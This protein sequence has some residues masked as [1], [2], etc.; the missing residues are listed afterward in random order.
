[1]RAG[2]DAAALKRYSEGLAAAQI[3]GRELDGA[4]PA[5]CLRG[6]CALAHRVPPKAT[7]FMTSLLEQ[8]QRVCQKTRYGL[9]SRLSA[10]ERRLYVTVVQESLVLPEPFALRS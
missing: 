5:F 9:W 1:V 3:L 8:V 2:G 4:L 10:K 6:L 7:R